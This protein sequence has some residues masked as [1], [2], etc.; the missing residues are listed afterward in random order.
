MHLLTSNFNLMSSNSNWS[1]LKKNSYKI[2]ENFD[3]F[4]FFI[5][6][7]NILKKYDSINIILDYNNS[8][9]K[10]I[11]EKL[12][13]IKNYNNKNKISIFFLLN[14]NKKKNSISQKN[15]EQN[16]KEIKSIDNINF[17]FIEKNIKIKFNKRNQ[18]YLS[19]P[20]EIDSVNE[21][22]K[23]LLGNN[24]IL[25]PKNY[26]LIVLDCDNTLWGGVLDEDGK[27]NIKYSKKGV[28]SIYYNFQKFFKSLKKKG[29]L[30]SI[31]SKN[32]EKK[33]WE[34]MKYKNMILKK[35]DFIF[36]KIN[37][38]EKKNNIKEILSKMSLRAEDTLFIDD[39]LI[40]IEKVKIGIPEI[41]CIHFNKKNILQ[42]LNKEKKLKKSV[43]LKEDLNKYNQYKLR[44][45]FEESKE[46]NL[47][48]LN[49][50]GFLKS[51]KQ[52]IKF[53]KLNSKNKA[54]SIQLFNKTNQFNFTLN[55]Y[56]DFELMN[57]LKDKSFK[58]NLVKF[59]DKFGDHGLIGLYLLKIEEDKI[60]IKNLILS[61]RVLFRKIEDFIIYKIHTTYKNK[62]IH[63]EYRESS[64]NNKL[65]P[66]FLNNKFFRF[67]SMKGEIKKYS[68]TSTKSLYETKKIFN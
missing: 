22:S 61:C 29:F 5:N 24:K 3:N 11:F 50:L 47:N 57:I 23:I 6:N 7:K 9:K 68:I 60:I 33:V 27:E 66:K 2:D 4:Y 25:S 38:S 59:D 40:E 32:E 10:E 26:K 44:S 37:W 54:R 52:K 64:L 36:P 46:K 21:V 14:D 67:Y 51:L 39:N 48:N 58:L 19:F 31:S 42:I 16:L 13:S 35:K 17:K 20:F 18:K 55:R 63:I 53:V 45:K 41:N 56:N 12:Q 30:L 8:N 65:I 1:F 15:I 28:N 49:E 43:I 34:A 62:K